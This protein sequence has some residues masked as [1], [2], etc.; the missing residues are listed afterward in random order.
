MRDCV[1][2]FFTGLLLFCTLIG[3]SQEDLCQTITDKKVLKYY[4][5]GT[6]KKKNKK[7]VR[8]GFLKKT[9]DL[10]P[11]FVAANCRF[12]RDLART[13]NYEKASLDP[14]EKYFQIVVD[15]CPEYHSDP[16]YY[17][18]IIAYENKEYVKA[19]KH[20]KKFMNFQSD[21][22]DAFAHDYD[23][24]YEQAKSDYK[25]ARFY[26]FHQDKE[27]PYDP[28]IVE[29]PSM[30]Y[31]EYLPLIS[32][33]DE[34][35]YITQRL[36]I[37]QQGPRD[38]LYDRDDILQ[39]E[40]FV[41]SRRGEG[42]GFQKPELMPKPFNMDPEA[43]Y[44]GAS[45]SIDNKHIFFTVCSEGK[46]GYTNCDIFQTDYVFGY[47]DIT[48]VEEWH[49]TE[50]ERLGPNINTEDGWE[51]QPTVSA[52][53]KML[54]FASYRKDSRGIDIYSSKK[55]EDGTWGMAE[56]LG[57]PINTEY[58][59]KSPF[60]H[61]DSETLYFSSDGQ[62]GFGK[63]DVFFARKDDEGNWLEPM[64]I[65][66]P[67]NNEG[68]QHGFVVST[69]GKTVYFGSNLFKERGKGG[70]D[71]VSFEL[72]EAARPEKVIFL[73]G[74]VKDEHGKVIKDAKIE[75]KNVATNKITS[76]DIDTVDGS[77]AAVVT[78]KKDQDVIVSV[79]AQDKVFNSH[80]FKAEDTIV[81]TFKELEIELEH[82]HPGKP[83]TL[84]DIYFD[85]ASASLTTPSKS[86]LD[87]F[88]KYLKEHPNLVIAIYGHT[89]N[90]GESESN[91][92]L[93]TD[94]AFSVMSYLQDDGIKKDRMSFKG[95]GETKPIAPN[96]SV[97]NRAKNRRTEFV[98]VSN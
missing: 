88:A 33:D 42:G 98:I 62:M 29:G 95:Y 40:L 6:D 60:M 32:P 54:Y 20:Y 1:F 36:K 72:Y 19:T 51:S 17:L 84:Y 48:D 96:N 58:N 61:T 86:M 91:M 75:M 94:R 3:K 59:D 39:T 70:Y 69:D 77:Y 44:G 41:F 38:R 21:N 90:N 85:H 18:G 80:Y 34:R 22:D 56:N 12:G 10:D 2:L 49:W 46:M 11:Y 55:Q 87:E 25:W 31:D 76:F 64:N 5:E 15:S 24:K 63:Y 45:I 82:I 26:A 97:A 14:C 53:G 65:G 78:L 47:N 73:K 68:D 92:H 28:V 8:M 67:I 52:D 43:N 23:R 79:K 93:S 4:K 50:L 9:L 89:D 57:E 16:Y 37:E 81:D 66:S 13:L 27:V 71:I 83:F 74:N 7:D 35:M 30:K